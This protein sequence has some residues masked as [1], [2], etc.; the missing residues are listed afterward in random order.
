MGQQSPMISS[1]I[2]INTH[3][4]ISGI[5]KHAERTQVQHPQ[6]Q[7]DR[8]DAN[9]NSGCGKV[10]HRGQ[11]ERCGILRKFFIVYAALKK[12]IEEKYGG[13]WQIVIGK[14][15]SVYFD[16]TVI[17]DYIILQTEIKRMIIFRKKN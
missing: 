13:K 5:R 7:N 14:D 11:Q 1:S 15:M 4:F 9:L 12:V 8:G 2:L 3:I 10:G 6:I 16:E 17:K